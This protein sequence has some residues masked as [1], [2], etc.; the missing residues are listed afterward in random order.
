M[1]IADNFFTYVF[2]MLRYCQLC[3]T[4]LS[5]TATLIKCLRLGG[6]MVRTLDL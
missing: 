3:G 1:N 5:R 6:V 2:M 4:V